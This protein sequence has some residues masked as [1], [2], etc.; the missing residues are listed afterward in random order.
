MQLDEGGVGRRNSGSIA[1]RAPSVRLAWRVNEKERPWRQKR[2]TR[3]PLRGWRGLW[4]LEDEARL[5]QEKRVVDETWKFSLLP[6]REIDVEH[7]KQ[8]HLA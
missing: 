3:W 1:C 4:S 7:P 5:R 2:G 8:Y 6:D